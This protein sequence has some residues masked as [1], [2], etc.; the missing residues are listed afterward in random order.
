MRFYSKF[1]AVGLRTSALRSNLSRS[2]AFC[3][4]CPFQNSNVLMAA[5][6]VCNL[7]L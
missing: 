3:V 6:M 4:H 5:F 7:H 1:V 2:F